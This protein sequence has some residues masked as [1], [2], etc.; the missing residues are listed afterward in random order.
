[1]A[2]PEGKSRGSGWEPPDDGAVPVRAAAEWQERLD[3]AAPGLVERC[4]LVGK[5]P[6]SIILR[7]RAPGFGEVCVKYD[8]TPGGL[9]RLQAEHEALGAYREAAGDTGPF[10]VPLPCA[11]VPDP[12]GGAALV[13]RWID[14][15]RA[16]DRLARP[17]PFGRVREEV[18]QR[19]AGWLAGFHRLGPSE[20]VPLRSALDLPSLMVD[21]HAALDPAGGGKGRDPA[22]D[23]LGEAIERGQRIPVRLTT[24]HDDYLPQN[25]FLCPERTL[26]IDFTL[27]INGPALRD[28]GSFL[29]NMVWRG[30]STLDPGGAARFAQDADAFVSAYYA[31]A[32]PPER[33]AAKLFVLAALA[34]KAGGLS[35]KI[36]SRRFG[37]SDRLHRRMIVGA[38]REALP[39][40][41]RVAPSPP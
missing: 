14:C 24:V 4:T 41:S 2:L 20:E 3:A 13:T 37:A 39:S 30:Y 9:A 34:R 7:G 33:Q 16:D 17:L 22:L 26:G 32:A 5:R 28:V 12:R 31:G 35:A 15:P 6:R 40:A 11:L 38:I 18:L 23:A 29:A 1:M 8:P 21:L 19:A 10:G 25:L 27:E 36:A